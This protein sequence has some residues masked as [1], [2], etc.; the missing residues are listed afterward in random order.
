MQPLTFIEFLKQR[1]YSDDADGKLFVE[2]KEYLHEWVDDQRAVLTEDRFNE[3]V[4]QYLVETLKTITLSYSSYEEQHMLAN[5]DWRDT[6]ELKQ[7]VPFYSRK[8]LEICKFYRTKREGIRAIAYRNSFKGSTKSLEEI[9]YQKIF[10]W[11]FDS[12]NIMPSIKEIRRDFGVSI[13]QFVDTYA[14]YFNI[15]RDKK[16]Q[17]TTRADSD[18][19]TANMND[20][21]YRYYL[22]VEEVVGGMLYQGNVWLDEIP[23]IAQLALDLTQECVGD[24]LA[25]K[26]TLSYKSTINQVELTERVN[27]KRRLYEKFLGVDLWYAYKDKDG[28]VAMDVLCRA[29]NPTGNL[30]N[31]DTPDTATTFSG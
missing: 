8:I 22:Q 31:C 24:L 29:K 16:L 11:L 6:K 21:D 3:R 18:M 2:Y 14:E 25:M 15:P 4:E 5:I 19:I 12:R 28:K 13:E 23:L 17:D 30:L 9:V 26:N 27:L 7:L 20:V 1:G 10:D